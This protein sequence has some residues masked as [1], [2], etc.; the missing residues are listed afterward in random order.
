MAVREPSFEERMAQQQTRWQNQ[1]DR[2]V[3]DSANIHPADRDSHIRHLA[4]CAGLPPTFTQPIYGTIGRGGG[5]NLYSHDELVR[6]R[7]R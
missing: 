7:K 4:K 5:V 6:G 2:I 1:Y 3:R